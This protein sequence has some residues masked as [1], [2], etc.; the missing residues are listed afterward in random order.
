[1]IAIVMPGTEHNYTCAEE[2]WNLCCQ[3]RLFIVIFACILTGLWYTVA[4]GHALQISACW[5]FRPA[6]HYCPYVVF[7]LLSLLSM[8][9]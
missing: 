8:L 4:T 1:V 3:G 5:L 9:L 2:R 6:S 7:W